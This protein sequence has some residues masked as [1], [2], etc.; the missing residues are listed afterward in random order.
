MDDDPGLSDDLEAL[1]ALAEMGYIDRDSPEYGIAKHFLHKGLDAL[2][3]KQRY[4]FDKYV[5]PVLHK[6][7]QTCGE[8][9]ELSAL[10]NA[11][12]EGL[13]L[14]SYHMHIRFK[15]D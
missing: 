15:D 14:C 3:E 1:D 8:A 13:M 7:C 6:S 12:D 9:I 10:P 5:A 4:I 2:S 11:Y